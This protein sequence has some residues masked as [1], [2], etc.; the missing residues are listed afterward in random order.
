MQPTSNAKAISGL[1]IAVVVLASI[2]LATFVIGWIFVVLGGSLFNDWGPRALEY[3]LQ[4]HDYGSHHGYVDDYG[5]TV[6][7]IMELGNFGLFVGGA[8][9]LWEALMSAVSLVAG[10]LGV[11]NGKIP[12]K[13]GSVF[14]WGI[15]A[16]IC[17]L[18]SGRVIAMILSIIVAVLA[19]RDKRSS[20]P[21]AYADPRTYGA[22][23]GYGTPQTPGYYDSSFYGNSSSTVAPAEYPAPA[24]QASTAGAAPTGYPASAPQ[25]PPPGVASNSSPKGND[26]VQV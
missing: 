2:A 4:H 13:L 6:G 22:T 10:I 7:D 20:I 16:A 14:G 15:A 3:G 9:V 8:A 19:Y 17:S 1:S 23:Q 11:K 18:L 21:A 5:L 25:C 26:S 12:E 24:S